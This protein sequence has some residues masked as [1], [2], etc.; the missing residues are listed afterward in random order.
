[1]VDVSVALEVILL[2]SFGGPEPGRGDVN[3]VCSVL[4]K[5]VKYLSSVIPGL[6]GV[7]VF[8]S[9]KTEFSCFATKTFQ[10]VDTNSTGKTLWK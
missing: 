5:I 10:Q 4:R 2:D 3:C 1:M 9:A 8:G 6:M 7:S